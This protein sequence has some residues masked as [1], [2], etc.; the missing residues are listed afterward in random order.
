VGRTEKYVVGLLEQLLGPKDA[1]NTFDWA[2]GDVSEKTGRARRLPFDAVWR[3][4]RLIV[5]VDEEQH[6]AP[7]PSSTTGIVSP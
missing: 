4:R 1:T 7:S 6:G 3:E 5:E 2:V